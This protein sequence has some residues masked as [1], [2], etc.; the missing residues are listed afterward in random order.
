MKETHQ[1]HKWFITFTVMIGAT[2]A[3][4]DT[5]IVNVAQPHMMGSLGASIEEITWVSTAYILASVIVMPIIALLSTR[6]GRKRLYLFS[7]LIF[8][9]G[10]TCCGFAWDL[11]SMIFFRIIQ[12]IGGG[13]LI[14]ASQAIMRE[15]FPPEEQGIAMGIYGLGVVMGPAVAPTLGGWL[16]DT[17]SW[18]WIFYVKSPLGFVNA[19]LVIRFIEDPPYLIRA[20][21]KIDIAGLFFMTLGLGALQIMLEKGEQKDWFSSEWIIVLAVLAFTGLGL[22]IWRELAVPDPAVDLH[23]L[24]DLNFSTA[25]FLAGILNLA[26]MGSLFLLPLLMQQLLQYTAYDSGLSLMPRSVAM[27]IAMPIAGKLYNKTGPRPLIASGLLVNALAFYQLSVLS[28]DVGFWDIFLPQ[29]LQGVGTGL[30]FVSLSTAALAQ[31]DKRLMT[32]GAGLYNVTRQVMGSVGI[33]LAATML[34]RGVQM[35]R[36]LLV[37]HVTPFRDSATTMLNTL[38]TYFSGY[39]YAIPDAKERALKMVDVIVTRQATMLTYNYEFLL[40]ALLFMLCIPLTLLI[41]P[42]KI[43]AGAAKD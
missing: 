1:H 38:I 9:L 32:A 37:E 43:I 19:L 35:N 7:V 36:A 21:R 2:M 24:K 5:S 11:S 17:Y 29:F 8:T 3:A 13:T 18:P 4:L 23:I 20:K 39:G 22:F 27:G 12:G 16:T 31:M 28:L 34:S 30:I 15:T 25:T 14:V 41:R 33:A 6:F 26:L 10:S 42:R 40:I